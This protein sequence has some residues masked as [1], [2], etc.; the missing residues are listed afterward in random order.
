MFE[1]NAIY[2]CFCRNGLLDAQFLLRRRVDL[3]V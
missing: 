2:D 3:F 1:L